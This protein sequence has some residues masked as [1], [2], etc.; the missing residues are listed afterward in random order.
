MRLQYIKDVLNNNYV[1]INVYSDMVQPYLS[2]LKEYI[3]NDKLY[4]VLLNNQRT[5][6]HNTWHITVINVFEYN[7]LASSIGMKTFLERL[8][9][10]FKTDIDDILLKGFGKAERNGNVAYYVVCESDFLASIRDSFGL[11]TLDFHCT[12]GFNR[13]D[14]H[15]VRKNQILNKDSK[16]IRRVR[17][18]YYENGKTFDFIN[19]IKNLGKTLQKIDVVSI[20]DTHMTIHSDG[21]CYGIGLIDEGLGDI[22]FIVSQYY[23]EIDRYLNQYEIE[24]ALGQQ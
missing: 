20:T 21:S 10:L 6:D 11:S 9:N 3:D 24:K 4:E 7:A 5:R 15:G 1:G 16:F 19:D 17:D 18:F 14:V 12:L 23:G 22:L 8:D 13:K 2:E